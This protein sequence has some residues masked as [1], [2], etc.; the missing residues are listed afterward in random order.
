MPEKAPDP[1]EHSFLLEHKS[2]TRDLVDQIKDWISPPK[3]TLVLES[4]PIPVKD[5]WGPKPPLSSRLGSIVVHLAVVGIMLL[6]FWRPV[7][8]QLKKV[9]DVPIFVPHP[10]PELPK[11]RRLSGGGTPVHTEA[12]KL[13]QIQQPHPIVAPTTIVPMQEALSAPSFGP[14]GSLAGPPGLGP[15]PGGTGN[16]PGSPDGTCT[17]GP[18]CVDGGVATQPIKVYDPDPEF[19]DEARKAKFQGTC[20]VEVTIGADGKVSNPHVVQQLGLGLDQKAIEAVLKWK[21]IPAKDKNGRPLAVR[22]TIEVNFR[23]F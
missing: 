19:T 1:H 23:L 2:F 20:E 4:K 13:I 10:E 6:P 21:F 8:M 15:G 11:I 7:R 22:A 9:V 12:P 5:I 18:D 14:V 17:S 16:G 3:D